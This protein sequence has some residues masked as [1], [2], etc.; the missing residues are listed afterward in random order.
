MSS[1]PSRVPTRREQRFKGYRDLSIMYEGRS[2]VIPVRVPDISV[3]GMFINTADFYPDGT[4][5]KVQF[6]LNRSNIQVN[7]RAEVRYCLSMVGVGVEFLDITPAA[8]QAILEEFAGDVPE[9][10]APEGSGV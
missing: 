5:L 3:R 7:V 9:Y 4:I 2:Q 8:Q 1:S 6:F 10:P